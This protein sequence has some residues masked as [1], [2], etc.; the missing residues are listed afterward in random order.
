MR[1]ITK[2]ERDTVRTLLRDLEA[3]GVD[4]QTREG[5]RL[6]FS[7]LGA[8]HPRKRSC[9]CGQALRIFEALNGK[10]ERCRAAE[11]RRMQENRSRPSDLDKAGV[12]ERYL[13]MSLS[14]WRGDF[15]AGLL[16]WATVRPEGFLLIH[17]P[18]GCGKTHAAMIVLRA[19]CDGRRSVRFAAARLLPRMLLDDSRVEGRP[20]WSRH[21][22]CGMLL[23]DDFGAETER[24]AAGDVLAELIEDRY[25]NRRPTIVTTNLNPA[26][27]YD[28]DPRLGSRIASDRVHPMS[29]DDRRFG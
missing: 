7:A 21:A 16:E 5:E 1:A 12:P 6:L 28:L 2:H 27:L 11:E 20:E 15:D 19:A 25:V 17:G 29:G 14:T 10:C 13:A 8:K 3:D 9:R 22:R 23:L 18:V 4:L 24:G 26:D